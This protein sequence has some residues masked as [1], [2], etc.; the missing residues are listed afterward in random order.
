LSLATSAPS[1]RAR[2][3]QNPENELYGRAG[4][5]AR[6]KQQFLALSFESRVCVGL[7]IWQLL[8]ITI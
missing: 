8:L 5:K 2:L 3:P 7:A 1:Q 4:G 6:K